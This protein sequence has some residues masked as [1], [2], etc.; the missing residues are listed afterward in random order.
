MRLLVFQNHPCE[1]AA[2]AGEVFSG[3][4]WELSVVDCHGGQR[5]AKPDADALL[6][7]GGPMNVYEEEKYPFL[8]WETEWIRDWAAAGRPCLGLC[9]GAQL[10]SKALGG[11]VTANPVRE[12]GHF[13]VEL[14]EEGCRD[15]LFEGFSRRFDV[16]QWHGD[17]FSIPPG[18]VHLASSDLCVHQAFRYKRA[19][20]L[21][22]HLEIGRDK[23]AAWVREY[24]HDP[25]EQG[26]DVRG[27]LAGFAQREFGYAETCRR[28][29]LNFC[30]HECGMEG[31]PGSTKAAQRA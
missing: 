26:V 20:G 8:R 2:L 3:L 24:V 11:R 9:L 17:T 28:L 18:G 4:G 31:G 5:P 30:R 21:Q 7:L 19:I 16:V 29:V 15:S 27:L 25:V 12:I 22:F 6:V 1:D 14:T 13:Q 23:M 10:L